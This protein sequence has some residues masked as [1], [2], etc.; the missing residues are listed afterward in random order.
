MIVLG[1][2][3]V[4]LC[5][6]VIVLSIIAYACRVISLASNPYVVCMLRHDSVE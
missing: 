6:V 2:T 3:Y 4:V 1:K 5:C